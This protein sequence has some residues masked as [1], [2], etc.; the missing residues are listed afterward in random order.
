MFF[1]ERIC[2]SLPLQLSLLKTK[3]LPFPVSP[4]DW[5]RGPRAHFFLP[6]VQSQAHRGIEASTLDAL[7]TFLAPPQ[8]S[9][10]QASY[11]WAPQKEEGKD[12]VQKAYSSYQNSSFPRSPS[13]LFMAHVLPFPVRRA[14]K[15]VSETTTLGC[16]RCPG[17]FAGSPFSPRVQKCSLSWGQWRR[18]FMVMVITCPTK[19]GTLGTAHILLLVPLK[20]WNNLYASIFLFHLFLFL[21][22]KHIFV[23]LFEC[24]QKPT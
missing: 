7:L 12:G 6:G 22:K 8:L 2:S 21:F 4:P 1:E 16:C 10:L 5:L 14:V 24:T 18:S 9:Q 11:F 23:Y 19:N 3:S 15:L 17:V 20:H 13:K